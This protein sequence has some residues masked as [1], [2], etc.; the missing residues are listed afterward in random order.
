MINLYATFLIRWGPTLTLNSY[1]NFGLQMDSKAAPHGIFRVFWLDFIVRVNF[2]TI[3]MH[4]LH[5][6]GCEFSGV[7]SYSELIASG[8]FWESLHLSIQNSIISLIWIM[9]KYLL[10]GARHLSLS[11]YRLCHWHTGESAKIVTLKWYCGT[12]VLWWCTI[13]I[14]IFTS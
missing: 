1:T 6:L 4:E 7:W 10:I 13:N 8:I 14:L 9:L 3:S 2:V 11:D 12:H 5:W